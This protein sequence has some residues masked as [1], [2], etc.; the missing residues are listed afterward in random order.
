MAKRN[1]NQHPDTL[2]VKEARY[3][4][5]MN[6]S[7]GRDKN[8]K[9]SQFL[10]T[11]E[12]CVARAGSTSFTKMWLTE[13]RSRS[14]FDFFHGLWRCYESSRGNGK[15]GDVGEHECEHSVLLYSIQPPPV[16]DCWAAPALTRTKYRLGC[17]Q[18]SRSLSHHLLHFSPPPGGRG[19]AWRAPSTSAG[20]RRRNQ[21]A[22]A[23]PE[24]SYVVCC[25]L[26]DGRFV[27]CGG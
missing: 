22:T 14:T 24:L 6:A 18:V 21:R 7:T 15:G 5:G 25:T 1:G 16:V 3:A 26:R 8:G 13:A 19:R 4:S 27:S 12:C 23:A 9:S 11:S 20:G 10:R 2:P 17:L